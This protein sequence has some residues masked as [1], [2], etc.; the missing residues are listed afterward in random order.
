ME[1]SK[2]YEVRMGTQVKVQLRPVIEIR[3]LILES[4][5]NIRV[6]LSIFEGVRLFRTLE[7]VLSFFRSKMILDR[8]NCF[9]QV[10]IVLVGSK[11]FCSGSS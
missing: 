7:Y 9:G 3:D 8:S 11:S 10:Q 1:K 4:G 5:I 6:H 2:K